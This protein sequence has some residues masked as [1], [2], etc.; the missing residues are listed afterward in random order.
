MHLFP[1]KCCKIFSEYVCVFSSPNT[2][3]LSRR[4]LHKLN[5]TRSNHSYKLYFATTCTSKKKKKSRG[6]YIFQK[7]QPM[8]S[9]DTQ[10]AL[11]PGYNFGKMEISWLCDYLDQEITISFLDISGSLLL[12]EVVKC[13]SIYL[14]SSQVK[15]KYFKLNINTLRKA[16]Y[17]LCCT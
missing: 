9:F 6:V 13:W 8:I 12:L 17:K 7:E 2:L 10:L 3:I 16:L 15:Y 14:Q 11:K 4:M 5:T 1:Q